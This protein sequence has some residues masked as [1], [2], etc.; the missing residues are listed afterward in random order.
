MDAF[1][2]SRLL[3]DLDLAVRR[4]GSLYRQL[5]SANK[6]DQWPRA[7][8][9]HHGG[10][11]LL[12]A[13]V[14]SFDLLM[15]FWGSLVSLATSSPVAVAGMIALAWDVTRGSARIANRWLGAALTASQDGRPSL[16][17]PEGSEPWGIRQTKVLT[18]V[19][20]EAIANDQGFEFYMA[21]TDRKVKL[22]VSPKEY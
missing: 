15:T 10:L 21:E 12:D 8:R 1:G 22:V 20:T 14:G 11:R 7:I 9:T 4:A 16:D 13:R 3:A 2:S 5:P 19:M 18:P 17:P 6:L